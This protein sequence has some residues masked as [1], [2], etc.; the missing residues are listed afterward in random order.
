MIMHEILLFQTSKYV[1]VKD[2]KPASTYHFLVL[3]RKHIQSAKSLQ[4]CEE[5]R[6]LR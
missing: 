2:I 5:D 6:N 3:S 4:P 1:I